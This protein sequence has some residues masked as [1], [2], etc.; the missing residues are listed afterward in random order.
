MIRFFAAATLGVAA[1]LSVA[2]PAEAA[3]IMRLSSDGGATFPTVIQDNMAGDTNP[4]VGIIQA[5]FALASGGNV[6]FTINSNRTLATSFGRLSQTELAIGGTAPISFGS[7]VF[8]IDVT[9]TGYSAPT[10]ASLLT[11]ETSSTGLS[12]ANATQATVTFQSWASNSNTEFAMTGITGGPQGPF[13]NTNFGGPNPP[14]TVASTGTLAPPYSLT[15]RF[16]VSNV[17]IP[18]GG[19]VQLTGTATTTAV[20]AVPAPAGVLLVMAGLPVLGGF[21]WL[22][23]RKA[24]QAA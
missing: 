14:A 10:G 19:S 16:T 12:G 8:V 24:V 21:S 9:D 13:V 18:A 4:T 6:Q 22:R 15:S 7:Q 11:S 3:F 17:N 1:V 23:R 2:G 20:S 5:T